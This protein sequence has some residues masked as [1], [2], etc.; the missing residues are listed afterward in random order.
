MSFMCRM[1]GR[2]SFEVFDKCK[3]KV[4]VTANL[5]VMVESFVKDF[6]GSDKDFLGGIWV[7]GLGR[8]SR[9][10]NY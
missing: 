2:N 8:L 5:T 3:R 9:V 10:F 4:V 7:G 6:L 1:R